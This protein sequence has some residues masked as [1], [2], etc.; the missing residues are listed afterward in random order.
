MRVTSTG[1]WCIPL[2]AIVQYA[3]VNSN[4]VTSLEPNASE[5]ASSRGL[6]IPIASA[7]A[8]I[9]LMPIS[10]PKRT[11]TELILRAKAVLRG[12]ES[13]VKVPL[14]FVGLHVVIS[15]F[16]LSYT[17][18]EI[19][20]S[21]RLSQGVSPWFIASVYTKSLKVEPGW[22]SA[23]T[24]SYFHD[25]KSISPTHALTAPVC[26]SMATI[27]QCIKVTMYL[28]ESSDVI[29]LTMVPCS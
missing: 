5:G 21:R 11:A 15:F 4:R 2:L 20:S 18:I 17:S 19:Y 7:V 14:A 1:S 10:W 12:M 3:L 23:V 6:L 29:S 8:I 22:R 9:R 27:A 13:P 24:L 28:I 26:G 16:F 25:L